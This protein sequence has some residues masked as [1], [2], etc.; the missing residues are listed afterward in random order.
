MKNIGVQVLFSTLLVKRKGLGGT[1]CAFHEIPGCLRFSGVPC[2]PG[3]LRW[4]ESMSLRKTKVKRKGIAA[5]VKEQL[6]CGMGNSV[7]ERLHVRRGQ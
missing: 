4:M 7:V 2:V 1:T 6:F 3:V 5:D